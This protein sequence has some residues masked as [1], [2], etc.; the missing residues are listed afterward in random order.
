MSV[1][2]SELLLLPQQ[3]VNAPDPKIHATT[4]LGARISRV[5]LN[6][7]RIVEGLLRLSYLLGNGLVGSVTEASGRGN[8]SSYVG[9]H[10]GMLAASV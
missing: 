6:E 9:T 2:W 7:T 10:A 3:P 1:S 4:G 8:Q 5:T